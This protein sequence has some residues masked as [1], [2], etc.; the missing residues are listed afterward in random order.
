MTWFPAEAGS[1]VHGDSRI[2]PGSEHQVKSGLAGAVQGKAPPKRPAWQRIMRRIHGEFRFWWAIAQI[3]LVPAGDLI[4]LGFYMRGVPTI[5]ALFRP[6]DRKPVLIGLNFLQPERGFSQ[7]DFRRYLKR[8]AATVK[9]RQYRTFVWGYFDERLLGE[10]VG[11]TLANV[12]RIE[13]GIIGSPI[14]S[15]RYKTAFL[16]DSKSAYF[17]GRVPTELEDRLNALRPGELPTERISQAILQH[18]IAH[19][20]SKYVYNGAIGERPGPRD[21]LIVGQVEHDAALTKTICLGRTAHD[22][23]A[24]VHEHVAPKHPDARIFFKPH[25]RSLTIDEDVRKVRKRWPDVTIIGADVGIINCI[26]NKPIIATYTSTVG[27]E[28]AL[29]G[30]AVHNF[31]LAFYSGWGFTRDYVPCPRRKNRLSAEDVFLFIVRRVM[32]FTDESLTRIIPAHD[33]LCVTLDEPADFARSSGSPVDVEVKL[34]STIE[35]DRRSETT[36]IAMV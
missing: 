12:Y 23:V 30:C 7:N 17:D 5:P 10:N 33:A 2:G 31:G 20:L 35:L 26:D 15:K 34:G 27:L 8:I 6:G 32:Q 3:K 22:L 1:A 21:I 28:A 18:V 16:V 4:I 24:L 11:D 36:P 14:Q 29:R 19:R 9:N 13:N 25:P